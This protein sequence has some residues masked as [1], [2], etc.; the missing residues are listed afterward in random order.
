MG[1]GEQW[2]YVWKMWNEHM[3]KWSEVWSGWVGKERYSEVVWPCWELRGWGVRSLWSCKRV[4]L[5][6]GRLVGRWKN[7]VEEYYLGE[8][9]INGRGVLEQARR[10]CW[11]REMETLHYKNITTN[12]F[13]IIR[14]Y[15]FDELWFRKL[16]WNRFPYFVRL[17]FLHMIVSSRH[18]CHLVFILTKLGLPL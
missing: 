14:K 11:E 13:W 8:R 15:L 16:I 17:M 10:E 6:K 9:D 3:F 18:G 7:R 1:G 2:K 5:R 12:D 4:S